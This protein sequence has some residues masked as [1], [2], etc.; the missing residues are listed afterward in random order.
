MA[1]PFREGGFN[2]FLSPDPQAEPQ[3]VAFLSPDPHAEPQAE[4]FLSPEPQAEPQAVA[5]LSPD[6]H[7]E[8]QADAESFLPNRFFRLISVTSVKKFV[9]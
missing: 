8:P 5:F 3:A 1:L 7:A 9:V 2:Q 6:P 4:A